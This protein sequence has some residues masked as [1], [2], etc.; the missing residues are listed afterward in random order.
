[1]KDLVSRLNRWANARERRNSPGGHGKEG[2][3]LLR[4]AASGLEAQQERLADALQL[5]SRLEYLRYGSRTRLDERP[6]EV[7][8]CPTC[9]WPQGGHP[10]PGRI[11]GNVENTHEEGCS[12]YA[13]LH[14]LAAPRLLTNNDRDEAV[15]LTEPALPPL[16]WIDVREGDTISLNAVQRYVGDGY[17]PERVTRKV[18]SVE[19]PTI[20]L[21]EGARVYTLDVEEPERVPF[22]RDIR[23]VERP[24][25]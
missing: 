24:D 6:D 8:E 1:M 15:A 23:L 4:E 20:T 25:A 5:L 7:F 10:G 14:G 2:T 12:L 22:A 3:A 19:W 9:G 17:P 18:L 21:A 11:K 13:V 16:A